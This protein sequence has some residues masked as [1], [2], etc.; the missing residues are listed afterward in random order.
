[1]ANNTGVN[2]SSIGLGPQDMDGDGIPNYL[3]LDS[4]NDGIP[5]VVES[6]GS[7]INNVGK[8]DGY[9]DN[10]GDGFADNF[11]MA[12]A[13]LKTGPDV[14][15]DGRADNYPNKNRDQ[16]FR[17]NAYD[18]DTDGD[19]IADVIEAGF[20]DVNFDGIVDG[21]K[22]SNGWAIVISSMPALNLLSTDSDPYPDYLD[23]DSDDDG[24]P[25]NIEGQ[26]TAGYKLPTLTDTD[27]DGIV[28][29]YDNAP[30]F[31]GGSGILV[32][33]HDG[34]GIPDYRDLD[35]DGDGQAD[36]IEGNDFNLNGITDDNVTPTGLDTDGDGL[37]NRFDSLNSV[38]NLKGTSYM[39]GTNG[40]L[41]GD[42]APGSRCTVQKK[43]VA[44]TNRDWRY[45][46]VVLPVQFLN[47]TATE[48]N[49]LVT[50]NWKIIAEKDVQSFEVERSLNNS[51]YI[52]VVT[53][54]DPVLLNVQQ[55]FTAKD[56]LGG[57]NND[58]IY[59][60]LKVNGKAGEIKYSNIVVV[61][62][63]KIS[64]AVT[65]MPNPAKDFVS[66]NFETE[67]EGQVTLR[68]IDNTGKIVLTNIYKALKGNN[69][70]R[71]DNLLKY[72]KAVYVIQL[73][74]NDKLITHKLVLSW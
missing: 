5:D 60:R 71:I 7:D 24:I 16:D 1:D 65:V 67:K 58:V 63:Q 48:K 40:S 53:V 52:N 29:I 69:T 45:V 37:D 28:N 12:T 18:M 33:D 74:L 44:Q 47:F 51:N 17:P 20:P 62:L 22:G 8:I 54:T 19:G 14:N 15:N 36:I 42:P 55:S 11:V 23:I 61:R 59:Y 66:I 64:A 9:T 49:K 10:N 25:D 39:M 26:T 50:L 41:I 2:G 46:G 38:T 6:G 3:D 43:N 35:T 4:D 56:D 57:I 72:K 31:F 21:T 30:A 73:L 68:L 13:I 34:D 32:Y 27:G 70:I